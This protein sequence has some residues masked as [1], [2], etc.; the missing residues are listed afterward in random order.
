MTVADLRAG[1]AIS[2]TTNLEIEAYDEVTFEPL[3]ATE[4]LGPPHVSP[5]MGRD[6]ST[7]FSVC[8]HGSTPSLSDLDDRSLCP[9]LP[10]PRIWLQQKR[11]LGHGRCP[12]FFR[13]V[14]VLAAAIFGQG[15]LERKP[16]SSEEFSGP[17]ISPTWSFWDGY[18]DA[19]P[20]DLGNHATISPIGGHVSLSFPGC[21]AQPVVA[22]P[23]SA[24]ASVEGWCVYET[25]VDSSFDGN[26]QV[27]IVFE[28]APETFLMFMLYS[29]GRIWGYVER[30]T[31]I[32]GVH[33]N[34][35][36]RGQYLPG[37]Y[38]PVSP[39]PG[40]YWL[41]VMVTDDPS[42]QYRAWKFQWSLDGITWTTVVDGSL[43]SNDP[44]DNIGAIQKV[45]V[46]AG[47]QPEALSA[48]NARFDH[49]RTY[50]VWH[51]D[52]RSANLQAMSGAPSGNTLMERG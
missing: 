48:F 44:S 3:S 16:L 15:K 40:P 6:G 23:R 28:T 49:F 30:F 41:R 2:L 46:F 25:K 19:N 47:N 31:N 36:F 38:W 52:R 51:F 10:E 12:E 33:Y 8:L 35:T 13:N 21:W 4:E 27:G 5:K 14:V 24:N 22:S 18:A 9:S 32:G 43:E 39:A 42:P 7:P 34:T 26:Q 29:H 45:G 11:G 17:S 50:P 1:F 37:Q 20:A